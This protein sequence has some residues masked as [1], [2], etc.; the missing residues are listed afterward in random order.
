MSDVLIEKLRSAV[1]AANVLCEGDLGAWEQDWRKRARGC[2]WGSS[3]VRRE[4]SL[5]WESAG[6]TFRRR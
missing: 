4:R 3:P 5:R 1:G 2:W 6:P